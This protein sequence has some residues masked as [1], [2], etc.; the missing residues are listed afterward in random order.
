MS[1]PDRASEIR[2]AGGTTRSFGNDDDARITGWRNDTVTAA[3]A[4][5]RV[6]PLP[7]CEDAGRA[8]PSRRLVPAFVTG[9]FFEI[10]V[11]A[12]LSG[13]LFSLLATRV[14][15]RV[16]ARRRGALAA[17]RGAVHQGDDLIA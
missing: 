1:H 4:M 14:I 13:A 15:A 12:T 9:G 5:G 16:S 8:Y 17:G 10:N 7:V 2:F 11:I 6:A 3:L